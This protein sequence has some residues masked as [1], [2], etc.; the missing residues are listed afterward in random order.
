MQDHSKVDPHGAICSRAAMILR[1]TV[2][3]GRLGIDRAFLV[4]WIADKVQSWRM[5][6]RRSHCL[7]SQKTKMWGKKGLGGSMS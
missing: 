6:E 3:H 4:L 1:S 2:V 5:V 7:E